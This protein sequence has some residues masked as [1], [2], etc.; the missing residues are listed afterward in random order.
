MFMDEYDE[1]SFKIAIGVLTTT[2]TTAPAKSC[3]T[4]AA[5]SELAAL[6]RTDV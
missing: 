1:T 4:N 6:D 2:L 5:F 3:G